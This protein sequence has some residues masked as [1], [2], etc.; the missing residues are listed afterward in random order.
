[1]A[2]YSSD[3]LGNEPIP[4]L[5]FDMSLQ[6][7]LSLLLYSFYS[8]SDTFFLARGVSS[9]AAGGVALAGPIM[10]IL[11]SVSTTMGTGGASIISRA[12]GKGDEEKA[13]Q[14]AANVFLTFWII[15]ILFSVI[16][17]IFLEPILNMLGADEILMPYAKD[18]TRIILIGAITSTGF[19][20]LIRAEGNSK[21]SL[22]IWIIPVLINLIFDPIFIFVFGF[23]VKGAAIATV[24]AQTTSASMSIYYFFFY[25]RDAY[26]IKKEHFKLKFKIL[27][28]IISIGSPSLISQISM[29]LFV[30]I[31]NKMLYSSGGADAI[32]A[33]GI[34]TRIQ[35][36]MIMP[37]SGIVQGLQP[38]VGY[39]F[40]AK[41]Y[42]RL[43]KSFLLAITS[44]FIYGLLVFGICKI[45]AELLV[46]I[47]VIESNILSLGTFILMILA[48]GYP[49]KGLSVIVSAMYQ[50]MGKPVM[51]ISLLL[52]GIFLIQLPLLFLMN[53]LFGLKG[54][55]YSFCLSDFILSLISLMSMALSYKKIIKE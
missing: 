2:K 12:L 4:K 47:F 14:T 45:G 52:F 28:E 32:T 53:Y 11:G 39:N 21:Y 10:M 24:L 37:Q 44:S 35:S 3:K 19:S 30:I 23:G 42:D 50:S 55:W 46:G 48:L 36:F 9:Y 54:V 1:M 18:Y 13:G 5:L 34:V 25:K 33:Y 6:T 17:L 38:I 49:F 15:S 26:K 31:I 22:Y 8:M 29:S 20:S 51:S 7:T 27:S 43:K 16:G 41:N 40:S